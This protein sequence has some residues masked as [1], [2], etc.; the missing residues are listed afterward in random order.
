ML[1]K[2]IVSPVTP[3]KKAVVESII[4][5][6][7]AREVFAQWS[8]CIESASHTL[9]LIKRQTIM[10]LALLYGAEE[11]RQRGKCLQLLDTDEMRLQRG[12]G[13]KEMCAHSFASFP[14]M[15]AGWLANRYIHLVERVICRKKKRRWQRS[16]F[17][18]V[19]ADRSN[20]I[21]HF[22]LLEEEEEK[23]RRFVIY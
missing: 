8:I 9:G 16:R 3:G 6:A 21:Y 10:T 1:I 7:S 18:D 20:Q 14:A 19:T 11:E 22:C 2:K 15:V 13:E 23:R 5:K 12:E 17:S 4:R